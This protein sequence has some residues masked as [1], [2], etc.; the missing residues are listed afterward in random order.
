MLETI[1]AFD[2]ASLFTQAEFAQPLC[3]A[4]QIGL[5]NLLGSWGIAPT[6]VVGHSSGEIAA[7][8]AAHSITADVA[9][10]IAYYRGQAAKCHTIPGGMVAVG[11]GRD[12][13]TQYLNDGVVVACENS[14]QST[15]LSGDVEA[16]SQMIRFLN[17][18]HPNILTTRLDVNTAYH[19]REWIHAHISHSFAVANPL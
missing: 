2:D 4:I 15:V 1:R 7:A 11:L 6:Q 5:V 19:S 16:V 3:V 14:P 8:Y 13:V 17:D 10:T 18:E 9:I 12:A